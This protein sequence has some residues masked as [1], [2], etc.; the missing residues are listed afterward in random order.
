[1][2]LNI[3]TEVGILPVPGHP[4]K[5]AQ[6]GTW[7]IKSIADAVTV[8]THAVTQ[9][10]IWTVK[11][12]TD[13][14]TVSTHAVT[15]SGTWNI[16][17]VATIT[18]PVTVNTHAVTQ[19]GSWAV[20]VSSGSI[21]LAGGNAKIG[22]VSID[23]TT[24]GTTNKVYVGNTISAAQSGAWT[25]KS[26]TDAVTVNTHAV[27]QSGAWNIGTVSGVSGTV[28]IKADTAANQTNALKVTLNNES[29]NVATHAVTQS[30]AWTIASTQSGTWNVNVSGGSL[31]I[32]AGS[33]KIGQVAIDQ[34]TDG[35]T[36]KVYVGNTVS[37]AQSGTWTIKAITDPVTVNTHAVTQ[38]G[39]WNIASITN[40]VT[41]AVNNSSLTVAMSSMPAIPA[42]T[43]KIGS[44]DIANVADVMFSA[45]L[46]DYAIADNTATAIEVAL[47]S[48]YNQAFIEHVVVVPDSDAKMF[49]FRIYEHRNSGSWYE[50]ECIYFADDIQGRLDD[51]SRLYYVDAENIGK[52][53]C[54]V[55]TAAG[56]GGNYTIKLK[57]RLM[58]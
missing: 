57:G 14:V 41:V 24:D 46:I 8:N 32:S 56:G 1:M 42:G 54:R 33:A 40:P 10:G 29:I 26:I 12:I 37:A 27:T 23:Q 21:T 5:V 19:S 50:K 39:A 7:L 9:S 16:G 30:G 53:H 2:P 58:R 13:P 28:T 3:N 47:P 11:A 34:T 35:T 43:N 55:I 51:F 18:N 31:A 6:D 4:I 48:G 22:T 20:S 36:N 45:R 49:D 15:Q 52:I 38:S 17:T 25:I 44:V